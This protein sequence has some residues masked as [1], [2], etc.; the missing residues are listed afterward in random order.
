M[1]IILNIL[2]YIFIIWICLID[3]NAVVNFIEY[4]QYDNYLKLFE[5]KITLL[6]Q[7]IYY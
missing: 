6:T 2:N 4:G 7:I 1:Q 5:L 3:L